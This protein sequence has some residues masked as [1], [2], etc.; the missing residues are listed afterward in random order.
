MRVLELLY[1]LDVIELDVEVLVH[2]FQNAL[3]LDVVFELHGDLMVDERLEETIPMN[4][5]PFSLPLAT[6]TRSY[7]N[8]ALR[9]GEDVPKEEHD[10]RIRIS[11]T[12]L[13]LCPRQRGEFSR[14]RKRRFSSNAVLRTTMCSVKGYDR[15]SNCCGF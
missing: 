8:I 6:D 10:N 1:Y 3:E 5:R 15:G 14:S 4:Q 11:A 9:G 2:A 7:I 12:L 13:K